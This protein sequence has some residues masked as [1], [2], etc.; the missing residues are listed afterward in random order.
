MFPSSVGLGLR[1]PE[2]TLRCLLAVEM[3]HGATGKL[4]SL[5]SLK[6][7]HCL[8]GLEDITLY[9]RYI[10]YRIVMHVIICHLY[11]RIHVLCSAREICVCVCFWHPLQK[12]H[13][14]LLMF[15]EMW[16]AKTHLAKMHFQCCVGN[17]GNF[18]SLHKSQRHLVLPRG[19]QKKKRQ[20]EVSW[21][22]DSAWWILVVGWSC[23]DSGA[24]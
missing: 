21:W 3:Y 11:E 6:G 12:K 15:Y 8:F 24:I 4:C 14:R 23:M 10:I 17:V 2:K 9:H 7:F 20:P 16:E 18:S 1:L 22:L 13:P 19:Q 5:T